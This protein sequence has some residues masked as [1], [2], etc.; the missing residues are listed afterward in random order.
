MFEKE[1]KPIP[2]YT[3][4]KSAFDAIDMR[5]D[6]LIDMNEWMKAFSKIEVII[7]KLV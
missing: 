3:L 6:G 7:I 2:N 4:M 1:T 5:K